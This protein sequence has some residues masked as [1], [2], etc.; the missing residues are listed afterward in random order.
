[1]TLVHFLLPYWGDAALLDVAVSSVLAQSDHDWRLTI[2]DDHH[3]DPRAGN[4]YANHRDHRIEYLRNTE[5]LGVAGN[6]EHCRTLADGEL[7]VFLG[8][9]DVLLPDYVAGMRRARNENPEATII[10]PRVRVIGGDGTPAVSLV[11]RVKARLTPAHERPLVLSGED[12]AVS[13]LR[14]NWLYWPSL[15]FDADAVRRHAFRADLPIILD[16][17]FIIDLVLDGAALVLRE[18]ETFCYRRHEASASSL[19]SL[20]GT[21]FDD[22]RRYYRQVAEQL[23]AHGWSRAA[24]VARHRVI[25]RLHALSLTP[26]ALTQRSGRGL[27]AVLRHAFSR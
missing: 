17:A 5:N 25:S 1:M 4:T 8:S 22:E 3:P 27:G 9:D 23:Q 10:Q 2:V 7:V 11:E 20:H 26:A 24:A 15:A 19:S 13:L 14:G 12:L 18:E 21:R 16:L 6:F